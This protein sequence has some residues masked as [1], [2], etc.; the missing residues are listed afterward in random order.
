MLMATHRH[1]GDEGVIH[2]GKVFSDVDLCL[3]LAVQRPPHPPPSIRKEKPCLESGVTSQRGDRV[4]VADAGAEE[5]HAVAAGN[6]DLARVC[7]VDVGVAELGACPLA[8]VGAV[9]SVA[10][11]PKSVFGRGGGGGASQGESTARG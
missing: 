9:I 1:D 3:D 11:S 10:C 5:V 2:P 8:L 6:E 7:P 4:G